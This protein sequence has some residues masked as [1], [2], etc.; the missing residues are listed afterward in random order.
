M[1]LSVSVS[2]SICVCLYLCLSVSICLCLCLSLCLCL[3]LCLCLS[4]SLS[5][6]VSVFLC[7]C[8]FL[9]LSF[10]LSLGRVWLGAHLT[11]ECRN[12]ILKMKNFRVYNFYLP[13]DVQTAML[14][15][16]LH[17]NT[18]FQ[19]AP[20][21]LRA[22]ECAPAHCAVQRIHAGCLRLRRLCRLWA[23][24]GGDGLILWTTLSGWA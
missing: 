4:L 16:M 14:N 18:G 19:G 7:L 1:S 11:G 13:G 23:M 15:S 5:V 20:W 8:L 10:S 22:I 24:L 3:C 17:K 12:L 2:V 6:S 21:S 9:S